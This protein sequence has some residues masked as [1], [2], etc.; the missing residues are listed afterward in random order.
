MN[1][2]K[3]NEKTPSNVAEGQNL[4]GERS[5]QKQSMNIS[6][7]RDSQGLLKTEISKGPL[8]VAVLHS[9]PLAYIKPSGYIALTSRGALGNKE[10]H[11]SQV[12]DTICNRGPDLSKSKNK[13]AVA[14]KM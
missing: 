3:R 9:K 8:E 4:R 5:E 7:S 14:R 12:R 6:Q 1:E 10:G 11:F 13:S 2:I